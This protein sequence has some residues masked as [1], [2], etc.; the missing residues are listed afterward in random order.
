MLKKAWD[1]YHET[2]H[3]EIINKM[4]TAIEAK[5]EYAIAHGEY[6]CTVHFDADVPDYV[7]DIV[8]KRLEDNNYK[9]NMPKFDSG[10]CNNLCL[11][12][13]DTVEINWDFSLH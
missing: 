4:M 10:R 9:V 5:I 2:I 8:K 6:S 7:R 11:I 1:A 12:L 3:H 13:M